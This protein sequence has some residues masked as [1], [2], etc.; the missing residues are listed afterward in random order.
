MPRLCEICRHPKARQIDQL[1]K[2]GATLRHLATK[3]GL[4]PSG[5]SRH[6]KNHLQVSH[7]PELPAAEATSFGKLETPADVLNAAQAIVARTE[8]LVSQAESDGDT[9]TAISGVK[10][11]L[12][13]LTQFF[14]KYHR[15]LEDAPRV[16]Q[17]TKVLAVLDGVSSEDLRAFIRGDVRAIG[18]GRDV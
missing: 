16:D 2:G 3:F 5:L 15:M 17:S 14:A 4:T 8:R 18:G 10:L 9:K 11:M 12:D 7:R 6:K 1:L 13:A